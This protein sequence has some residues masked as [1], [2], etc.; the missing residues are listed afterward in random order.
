MKEYKKLVWL[1]S[2]VTSFPMFVGIF[3]WDRLPMRIATH[4]ATD[5]S[6]NRFSSKPFAVFGLPALLLLIHLISIYIAFNDPKRKNISK[7]NLMLVFWIVPLISLSSCLSI[8]SI[9]LETEID[10]NV[11]AKLAI[12][13]VFIFIGNYLPKCRQNYT[14]GLKTP[15]SLSSE[16]NWNRTHR[17]GGWVFVVSGLAVLLS[18]ILDQDWVIYP[19]IVS[20]FLP[21]LYSFVLYKKGV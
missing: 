12:G 1:T 19:V 14:V 10:I 6:P 21:V 18:I 17:F 2:F 9:A 8:Y 5:N 13:A 16:E 3:L 20:F 7:K 4:F 15:W 11:I